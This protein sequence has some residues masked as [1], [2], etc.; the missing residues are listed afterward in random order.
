MGSTVT[1]NGCFDGL[2][3]GHL[4]F[5]GYCLAQGDRLVVGINSDRYIMRNKRKKMNYCE[6]K[7]KSML[8]SIGFIDDVYIYDE[9]TPIEF[10]K[11]IKPSVHC[12]GQ[13]YSDN[14]PE[15]SVCDKFGIE[16]VFVPRIS[17]WQTSNLDIEFLSLIYKQI[18]KKDD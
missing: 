12:T 8:L 10:I 18:M 5:L 4:F 11:T 6:S 2:H 9:D 7:R 14:C 13:E 17:T 3:P 1:C 16:L 15:S